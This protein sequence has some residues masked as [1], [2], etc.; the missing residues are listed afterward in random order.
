MKSALATKEILT[1]N[2]NQ[3]KKPILKFTPHHA[4][5]VGAAA[6]TIANNFNR[7]GNSANYV[8]GNDGTIVLCVPEEYRA[9]T[10]GNE[11]NDT[12]AIT[13]EVCN[14]TGAP[15]WK[16][17]NAALEALINLGVDICRRYNLAGF[18]WTG[19]KNGT[20][21]IH[22]M[23]QATACP[24]PYLEGKMPYIAEEITKRLE[25][26]KTM[27]YKIN[28]DDL[29]KQGYTSIQLELGA[30]T[31]AAATPKSQVPTTIQV[32]S[33]VKI[34]SGAKDYNGGELASFV[35]A[36]EYKVKEIKG[37][38]AVITYNGTVMAAMKVSD[39][40]EKG[41]ENIIVEL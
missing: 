3:R 17:S 38:R 5:V 36:R 13:V 28:I 1:S 15:D 9:W 41:Y 18:T 23:F 33:T 16:V 32:G 7:Y 22:K 30:E 21:T 24:G 26:G 37:D 2:Y 12:Q 39:L 11:D 35:Y 14:S 31:E 29:K 20:L 6:E 27:V 34:K 4:A 10:S 40:K 19:D 25:G 8:I